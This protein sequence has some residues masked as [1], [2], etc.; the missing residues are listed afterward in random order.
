MLNKIFELKDESIFLNI[1]TY[2]SFSNGDLNENDINEKKINGGGLVDTI[3]VYIFETSFPLL[4]TFSII[5]VFI[6]L[7]YQTIKLRKKLK[8]KKIRKNLFFNRE[9]FT[10]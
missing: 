4:T 6:F 9:K 3:N 2:D 7:T 8:L 1:K 5:I 10:R